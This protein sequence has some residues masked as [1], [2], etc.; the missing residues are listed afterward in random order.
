MQRRK[1]R[2]ESEILFPKRSYHSGSRRS[3]F[4]IGNPLCVLFG[5]EEEAVPLVVSSLPKYCLNYV[6]AILSAVIAAY[7]FSTKRTQYAIPLNVCRSLIFNFLCIN[8]LPLIF[9]ADFVWYTVAI[10]ELCC[11]VI[12]VVLWRVSERKGIVY[13]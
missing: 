10:A 9:S 12:A 1:G 5:A 7:L 2:Q 3:C 4:V 11:F 6:F 13:K 8:F